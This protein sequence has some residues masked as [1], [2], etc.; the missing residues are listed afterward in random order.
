MG[1]TSAQFAEMQ[2]RI[3]KQPA[4]IRRGP[5]VDLEGELHEAIINHCNGKGWAFIHS[6][7]DKRT[8]Q[9]K[10]VCDFIIMAPVKRTL[11]IEAKARNEKLTKDQNIF[12][13]WMRKQGH[14]V[15]EVRNMEGFYLAIE[16]EQI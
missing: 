14:T 4:T 7:M 6:R 15:Y 16:A 13:A 8:T 12:K 11:L 3:T 5:P 10:G 1:I 2:A 9:Q